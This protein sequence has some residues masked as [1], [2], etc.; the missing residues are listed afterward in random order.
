MGS[1]QRNN[2]ALPPHPDDLPHDS[3][4]ARCYYAAEDICHIEGRHIVSALTYTSYLKLDELLG[5]Q[6]PQSRILGQEA[7]DEHL[8]I[9]VHQ[10]EELWMAQL[11]VDLDSVLA[12]LGEGRLSERSM[13]FLVGRL[14]RAARIFEQMEGALSVLETMAPLDFL[15]F[16]HLLGSSSGFGSQQFRGLE[17]KLG[18]FR[19]ENGPQRLGAYLRHYDDDQAARLKAMAEGINLGDGIGQWLGRTPFLGEGL[20]DF[21]QAYLDSAIEGIEADTAKALD[22][23]IGAQ[24]RE[25]MEERIRQFRALTDQDEFDKQAE[26]RGWYFSREAL[27]AALL[28]HLYQEEPAL[29]LPYRLLVTL[30]DLDQAMVSWRQHHVNM[31]K[32]MIGSRMGTGGTAGQK[33]LAK[34][35]ELR[36]FE[37]LTEIPSFLLPRSQRPPLPAALLEQMDFNYTRAV[38]A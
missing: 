37:E 13:L 16:R 9:A 17:V 27:Q 1:S 31:V 5:C 8:F 12:L 15:D 30:V 3:N 25:A 24:A 18:V 21:W 19:G 20:K 29:Q 4:P 33:Y 11:H 22:G 23:E 2:L 32:R 35:T 38:Q 6:V 36:I 28:I 14:Q 10:V 34:R 26:D 7:L